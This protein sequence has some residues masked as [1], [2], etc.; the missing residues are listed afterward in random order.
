ML[1]KTAFAA[2]LVALWIVLIGC[3]AIGPTETTTTTRASTT[4]TSTTTTTYASYFPLVAG[5]VITYETTATVPTPESTTFETWE[6]FGNIQLFAS[7]EVFKIN[8]T[9]NGQTTPYYYRED[10]TGVY[11]YGYGSYPTAE[12]SVFL[13]YPLTVGSTWEVP[14]AGLG[15]Y[16]EVASEETI[17]PSLESFICRKI[18]P[19]L[20]IMTDTRWYAKNIGLIKSTAFNRISE[21]SSK[22]F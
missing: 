16:Y 12:P 22:N 21:I 1:K 8:V 2:L 13:K 10:S 5:R 6:Y 19:H 18:V 11:T 9:Y 7:I 14:F 15:W 3:D 20:G 4:T 17:T